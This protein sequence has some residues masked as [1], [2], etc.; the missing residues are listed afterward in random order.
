MQIFVI[1]T[2]LPYHSI[3]QSSPIHLTNQ[4]TS[5]KIGLI[6]ATE[7]QGEKTS[8]SKI[9][10]GNN[11]KIV[12]HYSYSQKGYT[13]TKTFI[14]RIFGNIALIV[15]RRFCYFHQTLISMKFNWY[16]FKYT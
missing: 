15:C 7:G 3:H 4:L 14:M 12:K 1:L 2:H 8:S 11:F 5:H 13:I 16:S 10:K 6:I 9:T